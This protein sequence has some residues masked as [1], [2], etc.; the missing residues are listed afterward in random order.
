[1]NTLS[2]RNLFN[3]MLLLVTSVALASCG[4]SDDTQLVYY[5]DTAITA[6][7][8]GTL[9]Q[10]V[11]TTDDDGN[12]TTTYQNL[13]CSGY[14]FY[15]DQMNHLIYNVDSLPV[16]VDP[17]RVVCS[18]SSKS[19]GYL[20]IKDLESAE[21]TF[22]NASDSL[23]FS[24]ARYFRVIASS[25]NSYADYQVKVN[26]H[27]EE[28]DE[29]V[30]RNKITTNATLG[31]LTNTRAFALNN[32]IYLFGVSGG[33][34][35][36]YRTA[37]TDGKNWAKLTANIAAMLTDQ[38]P[39]NIVV[40]DGQFY[41]YSQGTLYTSADAV[42]WQTAA[43][44]SIGRLIGAS[45]SNLYAYSNDGTLLRSSDNGQSWTDDE[46]DN[47]KDLL[48]SQDISFICRLLRAYAS[49]NQLLIVGNRDVSGDKT[50]QVWGKVE[51]ND[52]NAQQ[53]PW[54]YYPMTSD[55][56]NKAPHLTNLQAISY[57]EN[58]IALGGQA[59]NASDLKTFAN[60]YKSEDEGVTWPVEENITFPEGFSCSPLHFALVVDSQNYIWVICGNS[61]QIWKGRR[62]S[63]GWQTY[64]KYITE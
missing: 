11:E 55:V 48:P 42:S 46:M 19:G 40:K 61:G 12:A 64:E 16:G 53:Q 44:A 33:Q 9:K 37:E 20:Q 4:S 43:T 15:I 36:I 6:F 41:L 52:D 10:L 28:A 35:K 1:M 26:V 54:S 62:N 50:A 7:S 29:F 30:W 18:I 45:S 24:T 60:F 25:G 13:D 21:Y 51:Q 14:K 57:G 23:D 2:S 39:F 63:L 49:S 31:G 58:I 59:M 34:C 27:Q 8:V 17:T 3:L 5:D 22:F 56:R 32:N 38:T 47:S